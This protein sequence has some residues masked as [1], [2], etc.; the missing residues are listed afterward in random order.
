MDRAPRL[1]VVHEDATELLSLA[2]VCSEH[3][4]DV[5]NARTVDQAKSKLE[6]EGDS[7]EVLLMHWQLPRAGAMHLTLTAH[8]LGQS[9]PRFVMVFCGSWQRQDLRKGL[10][11][12][13]DA[14]LTNP[15]SPETLDTEL[16]MLHSTGS[17]LTRSR[18]L[19]DA[20]TAGLTYDPRLWAGELTRREDEA[21]AHHAQDQLER[22]ALRRRQRLEMLK[23]D[24]ARLSGGEPDPLILQALQEVLQSDTPEI[25]AVAQSWG[26]DGDLLSQLYS[27]LQDPHESPVIRQVRR[28]EHLWLAEALLRRAVAR[29]RAG[30]SDAEDSTLA[31]LAVR[32]LSAEAQ[33]SDTQA[34]IQALSDRFLLPTSIVNELDDDDLAYVARRLA[35]RGVP[36][37]EHPLDAARVRLCLLGYLMVHLEPWGPDPDLIPGLNALLSG[38]EDDI[39]TAAAEIEP[40]RPKGP[41]ELAPLSALSDSLL[42][43]MDQEIH[44]A[45][46]NLADLSTMCRALGDAELPGGELESRRIEALVEALNAGPVQALPR[47]TAAALAQWLSTAREPDL[48]PAPSWLTGL[49]DKGPWDPKRLSQLTQILEGVQIP[50]GDPPVWVD[51]LRADLGAPPLEIPKASPPVQPTELLPESPTPGTMPHWVRTNSHRPEIILGR[52]VE[53]SRSG[54]VQG[55]RALRAALSLGPG[56][57]QV[58]DVLRLLDE[59]ALSG[60]YVALADLPE[61]HPRLGPVCNTVALALGV[62]G[63]YAAATTVYRRALKRHPD[64]AYLWFNYARLLVEQGRKGEARPLLE[65][66]CRLAPDLVSAQRLLERL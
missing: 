16:S 18:I 52:L 57:A 6:A 5:I 46:V 14:F 35:A 15:I 45:G 3:G 59:S 53:L 29:R 13:I 66:A 50:Q 43:M 20:G 10:Q 2:R 9:A 42:Q 54:D 12:G 23:G 22:L 51:D 65:E 4:F 34:L 37:E 36:E 28:P 27:L 11:L 7:F 33:A 24:L 62:S 40:D 17:S 1:L 39:K 31:R 61:S 56:P 8:E 19:E 48:D 60:A 47:A 21:L 41:E 44:V 38:V 30:E 32:G 58:D 26:V 49:F 64:R 63:C 55:I 25:G